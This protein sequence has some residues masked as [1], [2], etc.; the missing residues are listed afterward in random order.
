MI[1]KT[2]KILN[3][4]RILT[5]INQN[6]KPNW[7]IFTF[8]ILIIL[9]KVTWS[10]QN[11][12][13]VGKKAAA[14]YF[15]NNKYSTEVAQRDPDEESGNYNTGSNYSGLSSQEHYL[16]FGVG[17]HMNSSVYNW[18][19]SS[20]QTDIAKMGIDLTYR[21][22][23]E[24]E[25]FD[26]VVRVSYNEYEPVGQKAS[27]MSFMYGLTFPDAGSQFPLYFGLVAGPGI[28]FQQINDESS[29]SLD[30]QLI[31]GLRIFN[32]YENS[33]FFIEGGLKNHLHLT[34]D[35]QMNATFVSLGGVFTF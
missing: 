5:F 28:F 16:S 12:P 8:S 6:F 22:K 3:K 11:Y 19:N 20:K 10:S 14:K 2:Q 23:Q 21:L 7:I 32:I 15:K 30:Y 1:E 25:L 31:M 9:P 24:Y 33:G 4:I 13:I 29:I 34:S 17:R 35:G 26:Q 27:K 18:G